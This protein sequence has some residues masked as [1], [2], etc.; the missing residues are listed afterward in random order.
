MRG[1]CLGRRGLRRK[2]K[3]RRQLRWD[4]SIS[5]TS[6]RCSKT[7]ETWSLTAQTSVGEDG[8]A[9]A[10]VSRAAAYEAAPRSVQHKRALAL[11]SV[12]MMKSGY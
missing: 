10:S 2:R 12:R 7:V 6:V 5:K 3:R 9:G 11:R 8:L 1:R 4:L